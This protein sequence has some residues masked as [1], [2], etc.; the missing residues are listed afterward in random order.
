V[1]DVSDVERFAVI[2]RKYVDPLDARDSDK[3]TASGIKRYLRKA[4]TGFMMRA[5][6]ACQLGVVVASKPG[7]TC[8]ICNGAV[9]TTTE[10]A[11]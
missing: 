9:L 8:E 7:V 11:H 10:R 2:D 5:A 4:G 1:S 3:R 6:C